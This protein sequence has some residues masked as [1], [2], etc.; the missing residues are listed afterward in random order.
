M[1][2]WRLIYSKRNADRTHRCKR[3][4]IPQSYREYAW[5]KYRI[6]LKFSSK[7]CRNC[8]FN[9]NYDDCH[10][11][12]VEEYIPRYHGI[13]KRWIKWREKRI[14][15]ITAQKDKE[16]EDLSKSLHNLK[17]EFEDLVIS[18]EGLKK[19]LLNW[20]IKKHNFDTEE[21][22]EQYY[23]EEFRKIPNYK[24][25]RFKNFVNYDFLSNT[26]C[27]KFTGFTKEK[28][29]EQAQECS[30]NPVRIF[31][32]R[33]RIYQY[34][35]FA[36]QS[37][38]FGYSESWLRKNWKYT[39]PILEEKYAKPVLINGNL[40]DEQQYWNRKRV[41]DDHTPKFCYDLRGIDPD[42]NINIYNQDGTY[43]YTYTIQTDQ[44]IRRMS[45]SGHKKCSLIKVHIWSCVDGTPIY[46]RVFLFS[47]FITYSKI[48]RLI[49][50]YFLFIYV[51]H[52]TV[53]FIISA[54]K[55]TLSKIS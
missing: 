42:S 49:Y 41:H 22:R 23:E 16:Y 1:A 46:Q 43:Q 37:L 55:Y 30:L 20:K 5:D 34:L 17:K 36:L 28:I 3:R 7:M 35:P 14:D 19:E 51:H 31:H 32:V 39:V 27:Y 45:R 38:I 8:I 52:T 12:N 26:D 47:L 11:Q 25:G 9:T 48:S 50:Y 40:P 10:Y 33:V 44:D 53:L 4:C 24:T 6:M 13:T 21:E 54:Y 29:I 18:T 2:C 15:D